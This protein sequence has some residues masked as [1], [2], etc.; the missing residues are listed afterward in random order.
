LYHIETNDKRLLLRRQNVLSKP[1]QNF[2]K[3]S[4]LK[5]VS[6]SLSTK[7]FRVICR[8]CKYFYHLPPHQTFI[9]IC[10]FARVNR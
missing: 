10:L 9:V 7:L 1:G 8:S 2:V 4:H 6:L 3:C 5:F